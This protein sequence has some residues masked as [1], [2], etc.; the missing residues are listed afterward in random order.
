[1]G[2][3]VQGSQF[4]VEWLVRSVAAADPVSWNSE[5]PRLDDQGWVLG[6]TCIDVCATTGA[7]TSR[8]R[9]PEGSPWRP[10]RPEELEEAKEV[11]G[12]VLR[13]LSRSWLP[14]FRHPTR[15]WEPQA[16][17]ET[18]TTSTYIRSHNAIWELERGTR[19]V[20]LISITSTRVISQSPSS[21]GWPTSNG[22]PRW[23]IYSTGRF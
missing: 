19:D 23:Y 1:M 11:G 17:R 4:R 5:R 10:D 21:D 7:R 8:F 14:A 6:G 20:L 22:W 2:D 3:H 9:S 15:L 13:Y 18:V 12:R 16:R